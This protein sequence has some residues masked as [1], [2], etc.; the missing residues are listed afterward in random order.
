MTPSLGG[1]GTSIFCFSSI[2]L[3]IF[4]GRQLIDFSRLSSFSLS[5]R[6]PALGA[7]ESRAGLRFPVFFNQHVAEMEGQTW[8]ASVGGRGFQLMPGPFLGGS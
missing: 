3:T 5:I 1:A 2:S 7:F 8:A 6:L 4:V